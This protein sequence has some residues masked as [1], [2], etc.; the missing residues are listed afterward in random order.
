MSEIFSDCRTEDGIS[1]LQMDG[2]IGACRILSKRDLSSPEVKSAREDLSNDEDVRFVINFES[3][4]RKIGCDCNNLYAHNPN[5]RYYPYS[6]TCE[7]NILLTSNCLK[8]DHDLKEMKTSLLHEKLSS[9]FKEEEVLC[10]LKIV[11]SICRYCY[12]A[13][14][15][16]HCIND[17]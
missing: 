9:L 2:I 13:S 1:I 14:N 3:K 6:H 12:D 15:N 7:H 11:S 4:P 10:I 17:E 5:C 16:C 8:C